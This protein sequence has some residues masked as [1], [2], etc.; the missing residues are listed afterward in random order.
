MCPAWNTSNNSSPGYG[1]VIAYP[2]DRLQARCHELSSE[3]QSSRYSCQENPETGGLRITNFWST[4]GVD[5]TTAAPLSHVL[6]D[7]VVLDPMNQTVPIGE[8]CLAQGC[9][10]SG[11]AGE[12]SRLTSHCKG[13]VK[14][15]AVP[16]A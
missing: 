4:N 16:P 8:S 2:P 15:Y 9:E 10:C 6:V 5:E 3:Q 13:H 12:D 11:F 14:D 7:V 1:P